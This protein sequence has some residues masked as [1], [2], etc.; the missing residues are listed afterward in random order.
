MKADSLYKFFTNT[1][2]IVHMYL[3]STLFPWLPTPEWKPLLTRKQ[4]MDKLTVDRSLWFC[5][6]FALCADTCLTGV[7]LEILSLCPV[8]VV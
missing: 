6:R 2:V 4:W 3:G 5:E 7:I 8:N 1:I